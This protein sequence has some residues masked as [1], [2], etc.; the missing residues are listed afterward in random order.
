M[1]ILYD[2]Q[3]FTMQQYGGISRYYYELIRRFG[4][5]PSCDVGMIFSSNAYLNSASHLKIY[6][7]FE[8]STFKGKKL[9]INQC[10]TF[11]NNFLLRQQKFDLFHPTYYNDYFLKT[12]GNKPFVATFHDMIHEKFSEQFPEFL[13]DISIFR[14]KRLLAEKATRIITVSQ[15]TKSDLMALFG[16][17]EEKIDVVYLGNSL[18]VTEK[19]STRIVA[20]DYLLF[21]GNRDLYKNFKL[22]ISVVASLLKEND[23]QLVCAG[24]GAFTI[25]ED[26]FLQH[27]GIKNRTHQLAIK[28]DSFLIN[29]YQ[30]ALFFTFPSLYEG[31]GIPVLESFASGCPQILSTGGSLPEVGGDAALYFDPTDE[32]SCFNATHELITNVALRESLIVKGYERLKKFSWDT[33]FSETLGVYH[34][35][36]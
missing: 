8:E 32:Q 30:H 9:F 4:Q 34:K 21:V 6:P 5:D 28:E 35:A 2:H 19:K 24:G 31:F 18:I 33:T 20:P 27:L 15:T 12:V 23:L 7:F 26:A 22:W 14:Q 13:Q 16:V 29:L 25:E 11:R 3:A 17:P 1:K 10:N 36:L